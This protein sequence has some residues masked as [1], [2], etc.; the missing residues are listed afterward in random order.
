MKHKTFILKFLFSIF[1]DTFPLHF[2]KFWF[3]ISF[4]QLRQTEIYRILALHCIALYFDIEFCIKFYTFSV[5]CNPN[6]GSKFCLFIIMNMMLSFTYS[7]F[8][9]FTRI[10]GNCSL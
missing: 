1:F 10:Y 4:S 7:L 5:H 6:F 2:C 3:G 9:T 8:E